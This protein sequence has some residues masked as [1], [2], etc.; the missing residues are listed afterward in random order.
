MVING[1]RVDL[2]LVGIHEQ[3]CN[4]LGKNGHMLSALNGNILSTISTS[5][6][7][8]TDQNLPAATNCHD[9]IA[10]L[11]IEFRD[12][13][14]KD[15]EHD[16]VDI[17]PICNK[18]S[19]LDT[20]E[21]IECSLWIHYNCAGLSQSAV[22]ALNT[23]DFVCSLC[24]DN[25]L[26]HV[27]SSDYNRSQILQM[28]TCPSLSDDDNYPEAS[29]PIYE[30]SDTEE[31][32]IVKEIYIPHAIRD[33]INS[34]KVNSILNSSNKGNGARPQTAPTSDQTSTE[35]AQKKHIQRDLRVNLPQPK[36]S[37]SQ[38]DRCHRPQQRKNH[39]KT[40]ISTRL[41]KNNM[42]QNSEEVPTKHVKHQQNEN[43]TNV[44][45]AQNNEGSPLFNSPGDI[46][47]DNFADRSLHDSR[48][49]IFSRYFEDLAV[50][51]DNGYDS[52]FLDLCN[53]QHN[54]FDEL[55]KQN[56]NGP[57]FSSQN[58][59]DA[60]QQLHS[61]KA[62]DELGP[63]AKHFKNSPTTH[64]EKN[65][66][67]SDEYW[68]TWYKWAKSADILQDILELCYSSS[69]IWNGETPSQPEPTR[70]HDPLPHENIA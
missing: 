36:P 57:Q 23:L 5:N 29:P 49:Q 64:C 39:R 27:V 19:L 62:T 51:K 34:P 52:E 63:A 15:S 69:V 70:Y 55:C 16:P 61:G 18:T 7:A 21:C 28:V 17:C 37:G 10:D 33:Q 24:T 65:S 32:T 9:N 60:I 6:R 8:G 2:C 68:P 48:H 22:D 4:D 42:R 35:N 30:L 59:C 44:Q 66:I 67:L 13:E 31:T 46:P 53:I 54:I 56:G 50:P 38:T 20:I 41:H 3:L 12:D 26:Y 45:Q 14:S 58:I 11:A 40:Q 47:V 43:M 1:S 25:M